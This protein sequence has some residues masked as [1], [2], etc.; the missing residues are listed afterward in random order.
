MK[1]IYKFF[2]L[3]L[4]IFLSSC[5]DNLEES[6]SP[7]MQAVRNGEF[8][9]ADRMSAAINEDGTMTLVGQNTLE[10]LE[11]RL[12]D[13]SVG[14]YRLAAGSQSE[15]LYTING[16]E[17][18]SSN[19][20]NGLGEVRITSI[21]AETG[22][23]GVFNFVS[24]LPNNVDTLYM[25]TGVIYQVPLGTASVSGIDNTITSTVAANVDGTALNPTAV[26]VVE[27][28]GT[29]LVN[30][31]NGPS[32]IVLSF[33]DTIVPGTYTFDGATYSANYVNGGTLDRSVSGSLVI[34]TA[35]ASTNTVTGTFN[36]MTAAPN[37]FD[38]TNGT[39]NIS[40]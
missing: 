34:L 7:A 26:S 12:Q 10:T 36:F 32:S 29:V 1:L 23:T 40:Y 27:T 35:D 15:A 6:N 33:P 18:F 8:F 37:N 25:R 11:F 22:V 2:L 21:N 28:G 4:A 38:I 3:S 24:Y 14:V 19:L 5:S 9:K 16:G 39:F 13:D 31:S 20:G 30:A 17:P